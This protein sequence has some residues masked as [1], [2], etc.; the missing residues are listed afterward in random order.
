MTVSQHSI[1]KPD[2]ALVQAADDILGRHTAAEPGGACAAC[3]QPTPCAT[4]RHA[5]EVYR[6]AGLPEPGQETE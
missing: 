6:A 2:S 1:V 3:G 4:A 5:Q